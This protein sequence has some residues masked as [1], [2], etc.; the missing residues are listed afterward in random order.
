MHNLHQFTMIDWQ[1]N[2]VFNHNVAQATITGTSEIQDRKF[3]HDANSGNHDR[4][5]IFGVAI[6]GV[7]GPSKAV[8]E[9]R[10]QREP[11]EFKYPL[12]ALAFT[13]QVKKILALRCSE[14]KAVFA[15]Y[16][17]NGLFANILQVGC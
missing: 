5:A 11:T 10:K 8:R 3:G 15:P 16:H 2:P 17:D 4:L 7:E 12:L 13:T 6:F 1:S 9:F 14:Y